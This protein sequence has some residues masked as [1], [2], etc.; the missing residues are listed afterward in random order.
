MPG[1]RNRGFGKTLVAT[2]LVLL[3]L[4]GLAVF[5]YPTVNGLV[6]D[7]IL[8][9]DSESFL[10]FVLTENAEKSPQLP[11]PLPEA[12]EPVPEASVK[13]PQLWQQ[14]RSYN[15]SIYASG[16]AGLSDESSY[17]TPAFVL[18]VYGL[19]SEV[20]AVLSIP[21]IGLE[22]PL[23]LGATKQHMADG[24]AHMS[25]TSLPI[26]GDNTNCVIAGHRGWKGA[27]YFLNIPNL[28]KGDIVTITNL[29][30]TLTYEVVGAKIITP[31]DVE[32][33][34]IQ[35]GRELLT[36]LTCHPPATGGRERYLVFCERINTEYLKTHYA[37]NGNLM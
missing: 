27:A 6:T 17:E 24:A 13:Y 21:A 20:F 11:V 7:Y 15:V 12:T 9:R 3:F 33:I 8:R 10:S 29:W 18:S 34:H 5:F 1:R 14:M 35:P 22:M 4:F 32:S 25:Q 37:D 23:Y 28:K 30:E 2:I 16:Q 36:L 31:Y 19:E 26:G